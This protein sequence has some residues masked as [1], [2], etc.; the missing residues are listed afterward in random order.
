MLVTESQSGDAPKRKCSIKTNKKVEESGNQGQIN[1]RNLSLFL[2]LHHTRYDCWHLV[3]DAK[4]LVSSYLK[5]G[6]ISWA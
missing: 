5:G 6:K 4:Y 1:H 3:P 2:S